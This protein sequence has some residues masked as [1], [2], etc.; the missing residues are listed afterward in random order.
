M[1]KM[2]RFRR[3]VMLRTLVPGVSILV[4]LSVVA[5]AHDVVQPDW[6][7]EDGTTFQEWTFDNDDNPVTLT[8]AYGDATA[9]ITVG[10][11]GEGWLWDLGFSEQTGIWDIGGTDGGIV[12]DIDNRPEPLDYKEIWLQ[13]TYYKWSGFSD[14]PVI[15]VVGADFMSDQ[16]RSV[17]EDP[18]SPGNGWF[19]YQSVWKI[20]PNP[21]NERIILTGPAVGS[22]ID[23]IVVDTICVPEPTTIGLLLIGGLMVL[24]KRR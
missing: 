9:T 23:Q 13:V 14:V 24:R 2:R 5:S 16:T 4:L 8:N 17:E 20:E 12:L 18:L 15:D 1:S 10:E 11:Y 22:R 3:Q 19:L 7:G 21:V 6:R